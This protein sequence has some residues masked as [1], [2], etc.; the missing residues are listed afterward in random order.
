MQAYAI[1]QGPFLP[2]LSNFPHRPFPIIDLKKCTL[3][4]ICDAKVRK[5]F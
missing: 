1:P 4:K 2:F 5:K 3:T